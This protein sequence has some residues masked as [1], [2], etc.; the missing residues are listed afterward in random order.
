A[1]HPC[2]PAAHRG[3]PGLSGTDASETP[4]QRVVRILKRR[5]GP[6]QVWRRLRV[7]YVR[8][9]P[10]FGARRA[11]S[12]YAILDEAAL[13]ATRRSDTAFL[14]GSGYSLNAIP[15]E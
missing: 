9:G 1:L 15:P 5:F 2:G 6:R 11:R 14:F 13:R 8:W 4:S 12:L 3:G 10:Y 7:Q